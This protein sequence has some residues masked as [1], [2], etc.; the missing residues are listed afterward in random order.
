MAPT[1]LEVALLG[2]LLQ[3]ERHRVAGA[4]CE[5]DLV[6]VDVL[7]CLLR[8]VA[9]YLLQVPRRLAVGCMSTQFQQRS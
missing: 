3:E 5:D 6:G 1:H 7:R 9:V 2:G 4:E 8:D